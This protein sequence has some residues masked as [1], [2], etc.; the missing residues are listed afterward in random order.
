MPT[1]NPHITMA[2]LSKDVDNSGFSTCSHPEDDVLHL[3]VEATFGFPVSLEPVHIEAIADGF[4]TPGS[5]CEPI[6]YCV[7][8]S[9]REG[10]SFARHVDNSS[11]FSATTST[12]RIIAPIINTHPMITRSKA[13]VYKLKVF[14]VECHDTP[15]TIKEALQ[16]PLWVVV[17]QEEYDALM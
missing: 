3:A 2:A 9:T 5:H 1:K 13:G 11:P 12:S 14:A 15:S 8:L 7:S 6:V 16:H 10:E 4:S 17:V